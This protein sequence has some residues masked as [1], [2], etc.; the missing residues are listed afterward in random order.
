MDITITGTHGSVNVYDFIIPYQE[1]SASFD[2][3]LGAKFA[4]LHIG[5]NTKPEEVEV[6]NEIPQEALMIAEF[7]RL[8]QAIRTTGCCPDSK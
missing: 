8:V 1:T 6:A 5:W 2:I 7:S 4:E 3:T